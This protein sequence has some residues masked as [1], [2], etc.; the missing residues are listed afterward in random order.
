MLCEFWP[1][2]LGNT[3][4]DRKIKN[5]C[6]EGRRLCFSTCGCPWRRSGLHWRPQSRRRWQPRFV[7]FCWTSLPWQTPAAPSQSSRQSCGTARAPAEGKTCENSRFLAEQQQSLKC[8]AEPWGGEMWFVPVLEKI[9]RWE[10]G[11]FSHKP[12]NFWLSCCTH[13]LT[14][15]DACNYLQVQ[16]GLIVCTKICD[17][18]LV[19]FSLQQYLGT[20]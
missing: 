4:S 11:I 10:H 16:R 3:V 5:S 2:H 18:Y 6:R 1:R 13:N 19:N 8:K 14:V 7:R 15:G 17:V 20:F 9:Q 12:L